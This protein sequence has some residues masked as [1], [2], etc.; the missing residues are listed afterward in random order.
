MRETA[1]S[2]CFILTVTV[3][4]GCGDDK[5]RDE[6]DRE[7]QRAIQEGT[8]KERQLYEGMQKQLEGL[9]KKPADQ[10]TKN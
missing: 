6:R 4:A 9:E 3:L 5:S 7:V 2:V 1:L 10:K 8:Q